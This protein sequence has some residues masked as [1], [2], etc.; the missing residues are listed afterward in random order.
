MESKR[1]IWGDLDGEMARDFDDP[2]EDFAPCMHEALPP[3]RPPLSV[4]SLPFS[5]VDHSM[6][7]P[8]ATE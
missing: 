1:N 8:L 7:D 6:P 4:E 2:I 3:A 5:E